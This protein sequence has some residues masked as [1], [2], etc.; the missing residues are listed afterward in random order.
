[1]FP[2]SKMKILKLSETHDNLTLFLLLVHHFSNSTAES[3]ILARTTTGQCD[4]NTIFEIHMRSPS[5]FAMLITNS[6]IC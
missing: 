3:H 2:S 6:K 1:M 4:F 5:H